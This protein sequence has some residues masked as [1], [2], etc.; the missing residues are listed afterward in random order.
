MIHEYD[1]SVRAVSSIVIDP[2]NENLFMV[3]TLEGRINI[4]SL[5]KFQRY[6]SFQIE[7]TGLL[8]CK[9]VTYNKYFTIYNNYCVNVRKMHHFGSIFGVLQSRARRITPMTTADG[10]KAAY[11]LMNDNSI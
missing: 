11:C 5:D 4:Y 3:G 7:S 8:Q 6:Y 1:R 2:S 9:F 10:T